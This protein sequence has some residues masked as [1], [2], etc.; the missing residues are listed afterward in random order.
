MRGVVDS[1]AFVVVDTPLPKLPLGGELVV[2]LGREARGGQERSVM[3]D[4]GIVVAFN[5]AINARDL[6]AIARFMHERHRFIDSAGATVEGKAACIEAWSGCFD[7]FPDY[8]NVFEE[9]R[10]DAAGAV[11]VLGRS[12][13][14]TTALAGPA[15][16]LAVVE[17][18]L[19]LEWR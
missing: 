3:S 6:D 18:G 7:A 12:E 4:T 2:N 10:S 17:H 8:R 5:E 11:S 16:W 15:L 14:S 9:I 13:C 1:V 19:V